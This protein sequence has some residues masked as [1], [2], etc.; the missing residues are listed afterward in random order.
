MDKAKLKQSLLLY[1]VTDR[2]SCER[3]KFL[4]DIEKALDGGVTMLQLRE[5]HLSDDE[6]LREAEEVLA[7]CRKYGV[8]M[9]VNDRADIAVRIGADGVHVG[10]DDMEVGEIRKK[11]GAEIIVGATAKTVEQA[12][13]AEACGA[14]YLGVGAVFPSPTKQNAKRITIKEM[15]DITSSV[16]I[17]SVAIGGIS[18]ENINE[19]SGDGM[20]GFAV[21]SAVFS[22]VDVTKAAEMLKKS[23]KGIVCSR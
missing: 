17:P 1:A 3:E 21:V 12:K 20:C 22:A 23:A 15:R 10:A 16:N 9:I 2:K 19:L 7:L 11:Y 18:A 8:P 5:K 4:S 6:L 14:D 13:K